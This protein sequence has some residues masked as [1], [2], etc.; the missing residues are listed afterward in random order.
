MIR[1]GIIIGSTRPGRNGDQVAQWV[2]DL[3]VEHAGD[4]ADFEL[5]VARKVHHEVP[6]HQLDTS[7]RLVDEHAFVAV[8]GAWHAKGRIADER[9]N[10]TCGAGRPECRHRAGQAL[11]PVARAKRLAVLGD[12][13][14]QQLAQSGSRHG[15]G[16]Q[17]FGA[18]CHRWQ[19]SQL[20]MTVGLRRRRDDRAPTLRSGMIR[21]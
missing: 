7:Q 10:A 16:W 19:R 12:S 11:R 20:G 21:A 3:A 17:G 18:C 6:R 5:V 8:D 1:I 2:R 4:V 15:P 14:D 13:N 9:S